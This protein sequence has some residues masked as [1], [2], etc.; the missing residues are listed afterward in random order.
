[1]ATTG[2]VGLALAPLTFVCGSGIWIAVFL[3]TR[4][5]SLASMLSAASLPVIAIFLGEPW[6]TVG[7]C[8]GAAVAIV[9]LHRSNVRRLLAGTEHKMELRR[10][11]RARATTE[12]SL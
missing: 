8:A 5:A 3:V 9:V 11:R 10:R 2:G 1:V 4:Y 7:F 6:P 12:A